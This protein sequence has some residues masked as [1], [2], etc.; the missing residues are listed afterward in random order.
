MS[1]NKCPKIE[2][3]GSPIT[4]PNNLTL[5]T[6]ME[7]LAQIPNRPMIKIGGWQSIRI[8]DNQGTKLSLYIRVHKS[9]ET[10]LHD[11]KGDTEL[12]SPHAVQACNASNREKTTTQYSVVHYLSK[13]AMMNTVY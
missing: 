2:S 4:Q 8:P 12:L 11:T 7:N 9:Q 5:V 1:L 10:D 6:G 3:R 13:K